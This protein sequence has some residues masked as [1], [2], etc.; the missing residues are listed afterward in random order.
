MTPSIELLM[1]IA[2]GLLALSVLASKASGVLGV[3][4][5]VLFLV[6]GML[7][8]SEGVG[9][10]YFDDARSAQFVGVVALAF[11]LFSGG[12]DTPW[13]RV[14]PVVRRGLLLA[15][16]GVVI[17][18]VLLAAFAVVVLG[19]TWV[20]GLLFG[21]IFSST[22]AAAV[23]NVM[24][25]RDVR[26]KGDLEPLIEF[27]SGTND[28][29]AVLLTMGIIRI[30][31]APSTSAFDLFWL[32]ALQAVLGTAFGF[33]SGRASVWIINRLRLQIDGLY[34]VV[35]I[36]IVLL[37]YAATSSLG[38]SGFIAIYIAGV[39]M[40]NSEFIHKRSLIRFHDGLAWIMQIV[41]FLTLGLLV[42]PSRLLPV[43]GVALL[44][45]AFLVVVARPVAVFATLAPFKMNV[46]ELAL[47]SWV[48]LRGAVP[49]ILATFPMLARVPNADLLFN[50]V[51]FV[52]L[53]SVLVQGVSVSV[54]ARWLGLNAP[55]ME[56]PPATPLLLLSDVN[57]KLDNV[58]LR[59]GSLAIGKQ[60]LDLHL[61][62]RVLVVLIRRKGRYLIPTGATVI[63]AGDVVT[64]LAN[65]TDIAFARER[66]LQS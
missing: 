17:T 41:M 19:V 5:L 58:T 26:L 10:I 23:F 65:E 30:I 20:E 12:L 34:I 63:E 15:T 56:K 51:F 6:I 39:I 45:S 2:G 40:G 38:G 44:T 49:I 9:G 57:A 13:A 27:E 47:V 46:R 18:A 48:G 32:F 7:A 8:G 55:A 4:S 11:I 22:D 52:V 50:L 24:R 33:V 28:P 62:E 60:I 3:P 1:L 21:A 37:T 54:V 31:T 42:F 43:A 53:T 29:M 14:R 64:L 16:A 36:A 25:A 61:P 35:T 59:E 66:I